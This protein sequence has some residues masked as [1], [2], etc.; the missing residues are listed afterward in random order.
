MRT[1]RETSKSTGGEQDFELRY[2]RV[3]RARLVVM[4]VA[5]AALVPTVLLLTACPSP[6]DGG[7]GGASIGAT[8]IEPEIMGDS[9][10]IP[11][12]EVENHRN[13]HFKV[14]TDDRDMHFMA[15]VL[16][17]QIHVRASV[18]PPCWGIAYSLDRDILVCDMCATTFS[19]RTGDGIRGPCVNY[20]KAAVAY[21]TVDGSIVMSKADLSVAYNDTLQP[22]SP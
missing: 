4:L 7:G 22:G 21:D 5:L 20:P 1:K 15:Y 9:V 19:A 12:S 10:S 8:W 2:R 18:C 3:N 6:G 11:T 17:G 16:N 14:E 13:V